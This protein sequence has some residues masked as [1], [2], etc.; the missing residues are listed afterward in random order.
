MYISQS[1]QDIHIEIYNVYNIYTKRNFTILCV[2]YD[3]M[4]NVF[5]CNKLWLQC[6]FQLMCALDAFLLIFL[7]NVIFKISNTEE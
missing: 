4:V 6:V 7:K 3:C 1:V 5:I 2:Q